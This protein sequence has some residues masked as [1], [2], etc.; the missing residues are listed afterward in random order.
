MMLRVMPVVFAYVG[1]ICGDLIT[2]NFGPTKNV[3]DLAKL[4]V[5]FMGT[6]NLGEWAE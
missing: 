3:T 4:V 1:D 6:P 2:K 5:A